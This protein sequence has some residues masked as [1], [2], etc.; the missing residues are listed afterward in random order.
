MPPSGFPANCKIPQQSYNMTDGVFHCRLISFKC[1]SYC[2]GVGGGDGGDRFLK[3]HTL[4]RRGGLS[5]WYWAEWRSGSEGGGHED[6]RWGWSGAV[7]STCSLSSS[8]RFPKWK[9]HPSSS[10]RQ[11]NRT[12]KQNSGSLKIPN[13][14][15]F[16][17]LSNKQKFW[18][19]FMCCIILGNQSPVS[20]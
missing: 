9:I 11:R 18:N 1:H 12:P 15:M 10:L 13:T 16:Q 3:P 6:L 20:A 7:R 17:P 14:T 8:R 4:G 2:T 5:L 19:G